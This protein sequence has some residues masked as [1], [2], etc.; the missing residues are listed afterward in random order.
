MQMAEQNREQFDLLS[1]VF[2]LNKCQ[3]KNVNF[4]MLQ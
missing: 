1:V 4:I 2:K 3:Y